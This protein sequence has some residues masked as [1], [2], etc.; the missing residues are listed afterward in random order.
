MKNRKIFAFVFILNLLIGFGF[1]YE[2]LDADVNHI[3]SDL[4]NIIPIC[5][6]MD[7][8]S[9]YQGDLYLDDL[10]DVKYYTP[11]FVQTLRCFASLNGYDY[12]FSLNLLSLIIHLIY[13]LTW[14]YFFYSISKDFWISLFFSIFVRGIIWPPGGELLG[15]SELWTIMPRTILMALSPLPFLIFFHLKR[16][17]LFL[18]FFVLGLIFNFHP[19]TG[20]GLIIGYMSFY[21]IYFYIQNKNF[22]IHKI[23]N[24]IIIFSACLLGML[25]Y[26]L[27]YFFKVESNID[28]DHSLLDQSIR[29]RISSY[30]FNP[31]S[32]VTRWGRNS[33]Y[34]FLICFLIFGFFDT[35]KSKIIFKSLFFTATIIFLSSNL[36]VYIEQFINNIFELH[37]RMSF[38]LI[39]FQKLIIVVFQIGLFLLLFEIAKK[40]SVSNLVKAG[41][42]II[43][44]LF[45]TLATIPPINKIPL[46]SD[47]LST[48]ILPNTFKLNGSHKTDFELTEMMHFIELNT[49]KT[50]IF[51]GN[52]LIRTG[53]NR[54]VVLDHK[55]ASMLIEGSPVKLIQWYK[56]ISF[57]EKLKSNSEKIEFLKMKKVNYILDTKEWEGSQKV[58]AIGKYS[59]YKIN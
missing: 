52:Y 38:Q 33:F 17:K 27:T 36:S 28:I 31:L 51:F 58:K 13:G 21:F 41:V 46:I 50:A 40:I 37:L 54:S 8:P 29:K 47:D 24:L 30:F 2:Q 16:F 5:K 35:S 22:D 49:P 10:E 34:F 4:A 9:L 12:F 59:L 15:I 20:L 25:P 11:F 18:S 14:F 48:F 39:R 56:D 6:K 57:F 44:L 53:A 55:G 3:S 32:F 19:I 23:Q 43:Y 7:L 1:F 42:T 45:L 26:L